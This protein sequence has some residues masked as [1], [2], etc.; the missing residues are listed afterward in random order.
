MMTF[1]NEV[2]NLTDEKPW[3]VLKDLFTDLIDKVDIETVKGKVKKGLAIFQQDDKKNDNKRLQVIGNMNDKGI[4]DI[5][6]RL[7]D[8]IDTLGYRRKLRLSDV[9]V[10]LSLADCMEQQF[11]YDFDNIGHPDLSK[12]SLFIIVALED[13]T[14]LQVVDKATGEVTIVKLNKGDTFN[15]RGDTIHAGDAYKNE[16]L[17]LHWFCDY[18]GNGREVGKTY[19]YNKLTKVITCVDHYAAYREA[20]RK[21]SEKV[22]K[23]NRHALAVSQKRAAFCRAMNT[24]RK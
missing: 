7:F 18:V 6:R 23:H 3:V 20:R 19:V 12:L 21:N 22:H 9:A 4:N 11:H 16:N 10:L 15:G 24:K 1:K 14:T 8:L 5:Q 2:R 17:R 13:N